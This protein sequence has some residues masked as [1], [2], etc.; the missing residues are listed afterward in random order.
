M[1]QKFSLILFTFFFGVFSVSNVIGQENPPCDYCSAALSPDQIYNADYA[2]LKTFKSNFSNS[3]FSL[4]GGHSSNFSDPT[5]MIVSALGSN[6]AVS[7][8]RA[9]GTT[10]ILGSEK[11]KLLQTSIMSDAAFEA[12]SKCISICNAQQ[13][14][15]TVGLSEFKKNSVVVRI[16]FV[17]P[18]DVE[19][20][21]LDDCEVRK[22][23]RRD[24]KLE[25][26]FKKAKRI[27]G[28]K[29]INL[30]LERGEDDEISITFKVPRLDELTKT[31][32]SWSLFEEANKKILDDSRYFIATE[33][34]EAVSGPTSYQIGDYTLKVSISVGT[35]QCQVDV[36]QNGTLI[37]SYTQ[38]AMGNGAIHQISLGNSSDSRIL[39]ISLFNPRRISNV[40]HADLRVAPF[41]F[42]CNPNFN[43]PGEQVIKQL[44]DNL[45]KQN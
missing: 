31:I 25:E 44:R 9:N 32:P 10:E 13:A 28:S 1:K 43:P 41:R 19:G 22:N 3:N 8:N 42:F 45:I 23:G 20:I 39:Y 4:Q 34:V 11:L 40:D 6:L 29:T 18:A 12:W 36:L 15:I 21:T 17:P 35:P 38:L 27:V 24:Q 16:R 33:H 30:T 5:Q 26:I 7:R 2:L 14:G 37:R